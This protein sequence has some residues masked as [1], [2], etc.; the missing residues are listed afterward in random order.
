[1][2][3]IMAY[4][5]LSLSVTDLGRS[6]GWYRT[7]FALDVVAEIEGAGFRRTRLRAQSGV[8]L[9]LTCHDSGSD[10]TFSERRPGLDHVAFHVTTGDLE[11][12]KGRFERLSVDHSEVK[13]SSAGASM[14]T[15]RDPDDIALE[16][17][18]GASGPVA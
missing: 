7:V 3:E 4:H 5:H 2:S 17:V 18:G 14:I 12:L 9:T 11:V 15:L 13:R 8:T 16:V 6:T 10:E 1:M